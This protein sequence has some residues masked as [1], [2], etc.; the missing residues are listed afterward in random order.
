MELGAAEL[1]GEPS[2]N[3]LYQLADECHLV[4]IDDSKLSIEFR[5]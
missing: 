3:P 5:T 4:D 1:E 2:N